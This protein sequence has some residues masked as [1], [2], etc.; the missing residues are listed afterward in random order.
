MSGASISLGVSL[1]ETRWDAVYQAGLL[2]VVF[3]AAAAASTVVSTMLRRWSLLVVLLLEAICLSGS[4]IM[5]GVG[6]RVS[7]AIFPIIAAMGIQNTA[8][9]PVG[10][11]RLGVTFMT[12]TLVSFGREFG[13]WLA[14]AVVALFTPWACLVRVRGG[15]G[16]WCCASHSLW[17]CCDCG[18]GNYRL[19]ARG[20]RRPRGQAH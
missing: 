17:I 6:W 16:R 13:R 20:A 19:G 3:V 14:S 9:S 8:L 12:G 15:C 7:V 10:G 1:S 4:A 5:G 18:P 2:I 11:V